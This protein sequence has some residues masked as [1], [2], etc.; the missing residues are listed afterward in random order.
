MQDDELKRVYAFV[1]SE[2]WLLPPVA[3]LKRALGAAR[4]MAGRYS[5]DLPDPQRRATAWL[6][7]EV[8]VGTTLALTRL[9]AES[10]RQ[11]EEVFARHLSER[12]AEGLASYEA[13]R[14]IAKEVDKYLLGVLRDSGVDETRAVAALGGFAPRPPAYTEPL[15]ELISR[16]A[17][18]PATT[19]TL[20]R[21]VEAAF[22]G[23]PPVGEAGRLVRLIA[24]FLEGQG[25][26][27]SELL[28]PL[29]DREPPQPG[30]DGDSQTRK[31]HA[32]EE[33]AEAGQ[34]FQT[35]RS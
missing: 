25:R 15:L 6:V 10:Y 23:L 14:E 30:A 5:S 28:G 1:R 13:M 22:T 2:L 24:T 3:A 12:L 26:L 35:G 34:L 18:S 8:V 16:L 32:E 20:P 4:L 29:R 33:S 9:A 31:D 19:A 21:A 17:A 11:P 7:E 27:S